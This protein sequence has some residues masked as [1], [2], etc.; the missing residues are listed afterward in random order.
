M[1]KATWQRERRNG[2]RIAGECVDCLSKA[3]PRSTRCRDHQTKHNQQSRA[4][5]IKLKIETFNAYG[6]AMCRC[7]GETRLP[8]LTLDHVEGDGAEH[9]RRE[10]ISAGVN[11][12]RRLRC[13]GYPPGFQV[14]CYNCN[15]SKGYFGECPHVAERRNKVFYTGIHNDSPV[16]VG[17]E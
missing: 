12:Y 6:G 13:T 8:L 14:L 7:C 17:M 15:C 3:L 1:T 16:N 2:K 4:D 5:K 9:R 10:G 11:T